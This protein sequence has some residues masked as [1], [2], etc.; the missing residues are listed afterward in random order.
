MYIILKC[1]CI[2]RCDMSES[3]RMPEYDVAEAY[4]RLRYK[5]MSPPSREFLRRQEEDYQSDFGMQGDG[6]ARGQ[7]YEPPG[8]DFALSKSWPDISYKYNPL[9]T[10]EERPSIPVPSEKWSWRRPQNEGKYRAQRNKFRPVD[11]SYW[12]SLSNEEEG[13][14]EA[15]AEKLWQ[16]R[17][18]YSWDRER[19]WPMEKSSKT[20][21]WQSE[22]PVKIYDREQSNGVW[23]KNN[24]SELN[25]QEDK[26]ESKEKVVLPQ[27]TM[28]TW[29]SLTSDPATW[30]HKLPGAKPWPK[31]ENGKSYN[32]NADLVK[33]LGLDKQNNVGRSKEEAEKSSAEWKPKDEKQSR[34]FSTKESSK[35]EEFSQTKAS[36]YKSNGDRG[37]P[38]AILGESKNP[39]DWKQENMQGDDP[40][41]WRRKGSWSNGTA[42]PKIQAV[43]AWVMSADQSTWKPYPIKPMEPSDDASR[44]WTRPAGKSSMDKWSS[45][46]FR[47]E[48]SND[49][50]MD[51]P[52]GNLWPERTNVGELWP[53]KSNSWTSKIGNP[54]SWK[55]K[56]GDWSKAENSWS[57]KENGGSWV[58]NDSWP[59]KA[60]DDI[61]KFNVE[62]PAKVKEEDTWKTGDT[63]NER[64]SNDQNSWGQKNDMSPWQQKMTEDWNY[65][66]ASS[67]GAWPS[68]W[69]QFAYHRVTAMPISKPGTTADAGAKSKNAFVAVSAVSSP[70]YTGSEWRKNEEE[71]RNENGRSPD[72]QERSGNQLQVGLERPIYAWKKE[73]DPQIGSAKGNASDPLEKELEAL[74]QIDFWFYKENEAEVGPAFY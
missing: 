25:K 62:W 23:E 19:S 6:F 47:S 37:K 60:T 2:L 17:A 71:A 34:I 12:S 10:P 45:K 73:P 22:R 31:D 21:S 28:K 64:K 39:K 68:K 9:W 42:L 11:N 29:N 57:V 53:P 40:A 61:S 14:E 24:R 69:K 13:E 74:R 27:I 38:W 56:E 41:A 48:K 46:G 58:R 35:E 49:S 59:S 51:Q 44:R 30:P 72:E 8:R 1:N 63:W 67:T 3:E 33:K 16:Q 5:Q 26:Q 7:D 20:H 15:E 36:E 66:K 18:Q 43:G 70:K 54:D 4:R 52:N 32:P 55:A 65:G 50:G